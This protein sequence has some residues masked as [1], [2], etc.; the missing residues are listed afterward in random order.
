[1]SPFS[2]ATQ[3]VS[4][5]VFPDGTLAVAVSGGV[6]SLCALVRCVE[7][8]KS[9]LAV[10]ALFKEEPDTVAIDGLTRACRHLGVPFH[11]V[12][13]RET[14]Q[15]QV[16]Q[17]FAQAWLKGNTPNPCAVCNKTMKFGALL[18]AAETLG[19]DAIVTGHY[20]S[21]VPDPYGT[22]PLPLLARGYDSKKDQSYF[23]SLVPRQRLAKAFFPLWQQKKEETRRHI[24]EAGL[25]VPVAAESQEICFIPAG[26]D[27]YKEFLSDLCARLGHPL[28]GDGDILLVE[29]TGTRKIGRHQGLWRYTEG[30]RQGIGV[31]WKEP[32][33][34]IGKDMKKNALLIA[35]KQRALMHG[36][37][38]EAVNAMI[39]LECIP[40]E[41]FVRLRYRQQPAPA[42]LQPMGTD[43]FAVHLCSPT[44]LSAP[45]Q[46][47]SVTDA[48]GRILA[49]G[50]I[51][52]VF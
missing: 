17:A 36:A 38:I 19:A 25:T 4:R 40:Q 9:C 31:A 20:A 41:I 52:S 8:G 14:F 18:D 46:T 11:V 45:G 50:V 28:S 6:D 24:A 5:Q 7:A 39:P 44:A 16:V 43:A 30:Q 1:M 48:E 27:H 49:G 33:Y 3:E 26:P 10:H 42:I 13:L 32:L 21:L 34:V 22:S 2:S 29:D 47:A 23:L 15:K 37:N 35:P 12:D 51:A